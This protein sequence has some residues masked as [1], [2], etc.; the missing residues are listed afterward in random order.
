MA[1]HRGKAGEWP[2]VK[3]Q[4][5]ACFLTPD[6][7]QKSDR[8]VAGPLRMG[9]APGVGPRGPAVALGRSE[10]RSDYGMDRV[11][12]R[13]FD[14]IGTG[15]SRYNQAAQSDLISRQKRGE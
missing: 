15:T 12:P 2:R 4:P 13:E 8:S 6:V 3:N 5:E 7:M 14:P 9:T 1:Q 10:E 11:S